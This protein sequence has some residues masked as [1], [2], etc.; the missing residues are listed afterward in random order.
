[1][2][3]LKIICIVFIIFGCETIPEK[4]NNTEGIP[5]E[6]TQDAE[7]IKTLTKEIR[8]VPEVKPIVVIKTKAI[9]QNADK[10]I[11]ANKKI[12]NLV[13]R[14]NYLENRFNEL[15]IESKKK[16]QD[17]IRYI[18]MGFITLGGILASFGLYSFIV[19]FTTVTVNT[20]AFAFIISGGLIMSCG[21]LY[22]LYPLYVMIAGII[23]ILIIIIVSVL[24]I[25]ET[26]IVQKDLETTAKNFQKVKADDNWHL[27]KHSL[28]GDSKYKDRMLK[29][30]KNLKLK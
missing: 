19:G 5:V 21:M 27:T 17:F 6:M 18:L 20:K 11:E 29:L 3:F 2:K 8:S 10:I 9:D 13:E 24:Q 14:Y 25:K 30:K 28:E 26:H 4:V 15:E 16:T 12:A 22:S 23:G 1:M 7:K